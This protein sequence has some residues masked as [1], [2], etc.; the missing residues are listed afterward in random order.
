VSEIEYIAFARV[1]LAQGE[2]TAADTLL[3]HLYQKADA[4]NF[5]S[6]AIE[7]LILRSLV[8]QALNDISQ[9][10]TTL[11]AALALAEPE[12]YVRVFIDEG[13]PMI[14]L[15]RRAG[16][17][18]IVPRYVARLL[19]AAAP[20]SEI[21]DRAAQPLIEPLSE[22]EI[23]VLGFLAA[24]WSNQAIA[25]K[26]VVAVGT[27]KAHTASIY[28]K[29]DVVSRTQAVARARELNLI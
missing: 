26:L 24:G 4:D 22:R 8:F 1:L 2:L 12:G 25:E 10:L 16:S 29:L 7:I 28:R 19:S 14:E 9:A 5:R 18:G 21:Q 13:E 20:K 23:E 11:G 27:V 17:R 15:L 6:P 3:E